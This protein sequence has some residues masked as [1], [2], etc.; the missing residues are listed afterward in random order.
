MKKGFSLIEMV[1]VLGIIAVMATMLKL[2]FR[3]SATNMAARHQT[4]FIVAS[5]IR[6]MQSMTVSGSGYQGA[7]ACGFGVHYNNS[8]SYVLFARKFVGV[9]CIAGTTTYP[10]ATDAVIETKKLQNPSMV[11]RGSFNDVY[12]EVPSAKAYL[13]GDSGLAGVVPITITVNGQASGTVL[14]VYQS[15][16]IDVSQ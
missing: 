14:S 4:A 15:G 2:N 10:A 3:S 5:D 13:G 11:F 8:T 16:K 1:V 12:F 9:A 6:R 7:P